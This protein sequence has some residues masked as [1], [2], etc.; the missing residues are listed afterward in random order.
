MNHS[1]PATVFRKKNA[2]M[3]FVMV[4]KLSYSNDILYINLVYSLN[5]EAIKFSK[6]LK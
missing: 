6:Y 1:T 3:S 5:L 4:I 2:S